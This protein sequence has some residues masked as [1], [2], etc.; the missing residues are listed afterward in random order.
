MKRRPP[1]AKRTD[2]LFPYTTLCR[3][4]PVGRPVVHHHHLDAAIRFEVRQRSAD[5]GDGGRYA[6]GFVES[7]HDDRC[8][9][10]ATRRRS[11][12]PGLAASAAR[13]E[14]DGAVAHAAHPRERGGA[15]RRE[16]TRRARWSAWPYK[17]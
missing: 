16:N 13:P 8:P 3:A 12:R 1:R 14:Q 2:T 5:L 7:G 15:S 17:K 4:R 11:R 10:R 9:N 6:L